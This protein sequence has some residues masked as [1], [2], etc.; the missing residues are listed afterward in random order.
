MDVIE[1]MNKTALIEQITVAVTQ[2]LVA[3][4]WSKEDEQTKRRDH[5]EKLWTWDVDA[6][7]IAVSMNREF[8]R[9]IDEEEL[10]LVFSQVVDKVT[11]ERLL[12]LKERPLRAHMSLRTAEYPDVVFAIDP[13]FE[14]GTVNMIS[15]PPNTYKSWLVFLMAFC[16]S[17]GTKFLGRFESFPSG[18]LIVN[19][20]DTERLIASRFD[21]LS[22]PKIDLPIYFRTAQ[23]SKIDLP[24][25]KTLLEECKENNIHVIFFDSLRSLHNAEENSSTEMQ[26]IMDNLK[27]LTREGITVV[28]THHHKK[29]SAFDKGTDS[30]ASRG[31]SAINAAVFGHI[32]LEEVHKD[33]GTKRIIVRHLKSKSTQKLEPFEIEIQIDENKLN[34]NYTGEFQG[35]PILAEKAKDD[36][37]ERLKKENRWLSVKNI[38]EMGV[39]QERYART[40]LTSLVNVGLA[41]KLTRTQLDKKYGEEKFAGASNTMYYK[42]SQVEELPEQGDIF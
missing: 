31:S 39:A 37:F 29:K 14:R 32:S 36:V 21:A 15:A 25:C 12:A 24:F 20:E 23:G 5:S 8:S 1:E 38:V 16:L 26:P 13:F 40:A 42:W 33:D 9:P 7:V 3:T 4:P 41:D 10:K 11:S 22:I 2:F 6:W 19:E 17:T 34:F 28:F 30:E 27:M 35:A 18:V